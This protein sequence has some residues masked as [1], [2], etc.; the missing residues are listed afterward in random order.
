MFAPPMP[1]NLFPPA[2]PDT[3]MRLHIIEKAGQGQNNSA[4]RIR[5]SDKGGHG[6]AHL[7]QALQ[8]LLDGRFLDD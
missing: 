7:I 6:R 8:H 4:C 3:F 5:I 2:D 1:G